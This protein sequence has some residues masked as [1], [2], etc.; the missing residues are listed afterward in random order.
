MNCSAFSFYSDAFDFV[1]G[2]ISLIGLVFGLCLSQLPS[3][4]VKVL[5]GLFNETETLFT[6]CVEEGYLPQERF[7]VDIAEHLTRLREQ[8]FDLR[9]QAYRATTFVQDSTAFFAGLSGTIG[10]VC[11]QV[12]RV[13]AEVF[14]KSDAERRRH[15]DHVVLFQ[16]LPFCERGL[17]QGSDALSHQVNLRPGGTPNPREANLG[18]FGDPTNN[19]TM[20]RH[21]SGNNSR[22]VMGLCTK[23]SAYCMTGQQAPRGEP[24]RPLGASHSRPMI[25]HTRPPV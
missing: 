19:I 12:K 17:P 10:R 7:R 14:T 25:S 22:H 24:A 8:T 15:R 20:S 13:R 18:P 3:N 21:N 16:E 1:A 23:E 2:G 9:T 6:S 4:K 5:E 11:L